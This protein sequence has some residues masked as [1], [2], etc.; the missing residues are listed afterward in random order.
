MRIGDI[1]SN[2]GVSWRHRDDITQ[3]RA[4]ERR[5]D[6]PRGRLAGEFG[7][8]PLVGACRSR[9]VVVRLKRHALDPERVLRSAVL[10]GYR[11]RGRREVGADLS[12]RLG[13]VIQCG[14]V[15]SLG[16]LC[17]LSLPCRN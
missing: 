12:Q 2:T 14:S 5:L 4:V 8:A 9:R 15:R 7:S 13:A 6:S 3:Q 11:L 16:H 17:G 1:E 10:D